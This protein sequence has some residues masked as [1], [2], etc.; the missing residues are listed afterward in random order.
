MKHERPENI[1]TD[2]EASPLKDIIE[3]KKFW[4]T[5]K[6]ILYGEKL[7]DWSPKKLREQGYLRPLYFNLKESLFAA[8]PAAVIVKILDWLFKAEEKE[9]FIQISQG[10]FELSI[11]LTIPLVLTLLASFLAKAS[12]KKNDLTP[13]K[14]ERAEKAYL[15][16]DGSYGFFRQTVLSFVSSFLA[17]SSNNN[18]E[19]INKIPSVFFVLIFFVF[20]IALI[21]QIKLTWWT[22]P[23]K[24]FKINGYISNNS[25]WLKYFRTL[26]FTVPLITLLTSICL[27]IFS[28]ILA[29]F[30]IAI[31]QS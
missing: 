24:L 20:I 12:L 9:D 19:L 31:K 25:P 4:N 28:V 7:Y 6:A 23:K 11:T 29:A 17:W 15:Y 26:L 27:F 22:I 30:L 3:F 16:F 18:Q 14:I 13:S 10:I 21:F 2:E 8:L 1:L 5:R